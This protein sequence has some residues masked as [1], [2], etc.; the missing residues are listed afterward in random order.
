M[1]TVIEANNRFAV[2]L[3][4]ALRSDEHFANKNLFYSPS[5]LSIALAMTSMGAKG[6]TAVQMAKA[7]HWDTM[8]KEQLHSEQKQFLEALQASNTDSNELL[9]ANRL[10]VQKNFSLVQ[11][12]VEGTK[13]FYDAEIALVDY[14]KDTEGARK[15][16]NDWVEEKTKQKI[17]N[18]IPKGVFG[19]TTRLTLVNAIYFKGFWQN[20]FHKKATRKRK[21]FVSKTETVRVQMMRVTKKFK[22]AK[23]DGELA[24]QILELPYQG[25]DLSMVIL[26]PHDNH[27]LAKLEEGLTYDKLQKALALVG[28]SHPHKVEVSLPRFK[29]TQQFKLN[30][31]LKAMGATDMFDEYKANFSGMY[32]SRGPEKLY[33]TNVI[34]KAFVKVNE[35]GTEAAAASA[36]VITFKSARPLVP[37]FYAD[38][39]FL[40]MICHKKSSAILFMGRVVKPETK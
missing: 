32:V 35:K 3:H 33:V 8:P 6:S 20:Q 28:Q 2:D 23:D 11:Q 29:L 9:A 12:F 25:E 31:I 40:F 30:K 17:K 21:F 37:T 26:L 13:T 15:E 16:V 4:R 38:H 18:L 19:K 5:S 10:F 7:L 34:H 22:H 27:G 36:V 14:Q 24:C 1:K 39:P